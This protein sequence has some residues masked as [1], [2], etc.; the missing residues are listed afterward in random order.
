MSCLGPSMSRE[1]N[2]H[3]PG[4]GE[5]LFPL[6]QSGRQDSSRICKQNPREHISRYYG[7]N[8][9]PPTPN[10]YV[11]AQTSNVTAFGG[12]LVGN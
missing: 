6:A 8:C 5:T 2:I 12:S 10:S 4:A 7:L 3:R 11:E 1:A 9:V